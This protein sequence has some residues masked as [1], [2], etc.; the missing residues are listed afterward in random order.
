MKKESGSNYNVTNSFF[1]TFAD[2]VIKIDDWWGVSPLILF[3][4]SN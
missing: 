4:G 3:V 1:K 2:V